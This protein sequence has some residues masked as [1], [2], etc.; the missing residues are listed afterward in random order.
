MSGVHLYAVCW[1]EAEML[2]FF[3]RHFDSWVDRYVVVDDGSTDGTLELLRAHPKVE[4]RPFPRHDDSFVHAHTHLNNTVW[5]ESRGEADWVVL[6]DVDEHYLH[7]R[8]DM[9]TYLGQQ[10]AAGVTLI[11]A[12]G[13]G[14]VHDEL[15]ADGGRLVDVAPYGRPRAAFNKIGVFD[16]MAIT[17]AGIGHGRHVASPEGDVRLPARDELMLWHFK[18]LGFDRWVARDDLLGTRRGE[19]DVAEGLGIHYFM[20]ADE[21]REFWAQLTAES[22]DLR[23]V[24]PDEVAVGPLWWEGLSRVG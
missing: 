7:P 17:D 18:H 6:A 15:P 10:R 14:M 1:N 11:P 23:G 12:I 20:S 22:R 2:G 24:V 5:H 9:A 8:L 13:F 16:P 19:R 21:R 4:V 3:F